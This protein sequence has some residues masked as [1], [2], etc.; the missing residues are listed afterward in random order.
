MPIL[1]STIISGV[2]FISV[3]FSSVCQHCVLRSSLFAF[4]SEYLRRASRAVS[5]R[6]SI[7]LR[8]ATLP[9]TFFDGT[10]TVTFEAVDVMGSSSTTSARTSS[11]SNGGHD[12]DGNSDITAAGGARNTAS[13]DVTFYHCAAGSFWDRGP[14]GVNGS[15]EHTGTCEPCSEKDTEGETQVAV[16][17][18]KVM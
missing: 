2:S 9:G 14:P 8:V 17:E 7:T 1:F 11:S 6:R 13:F 18:N 16:G 12:V 4:L 3:D 15:D 10:D 5:N